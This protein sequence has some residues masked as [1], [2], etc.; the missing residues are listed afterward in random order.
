M[1]FKG[2]LTMWVGILALI[3]SPAMMAAPSKLLM[4]SPPA[5]ASLKQAMPL[6]AKYLAKKVD[7][8]SD[9]RPVIPKS[10]N[11][12]GRKFEKGQANVIYGG[13]FLTYMLCAR[14]LAVPVARGEDQKGIST[15]H[16]V[17][18]TKKG[19]PFRGLESVKGKRVTYV[20][21]ASSGEAFARKFFGGK[22]PASVGNTIYV[23]SKSHGIAVKQLNAG[24]A[25]FAFVK[26]LA[27]EGMKAKYPDLH[28]V[29]SDDG[30]NPNNV[31]LVSPEVYVA[32]GKQLE[33][34]LLG[35]DSDSD[36]LAKQILKVLKLERFIPTPYPQSYNHTA[37]LVQNAGLDP[38]THRFS[39]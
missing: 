25:D 9:I 27:W 33:A 24:R 28:I 4:I 6:L 14:N 1:N 26:N 23:P 38:V 7:G 21:E 34:V 8:I 22:D 3:L 10:Y 32:Y 20:I 29:A 39:K 19:M 13:S 31:F 36:P 18:I 35:M 12:T 5:K 15:Y 2:I 30:E 17:L 37:S 16:S 11:D